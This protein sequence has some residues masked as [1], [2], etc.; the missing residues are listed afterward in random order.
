MFLH[1]CCVQP[2]D[3]EI[4]EEV[5][6]R[7]TANH[8]SLAYQIVIWSS[9]DLMHIVWHACIQM[10]ISN[11]KKKH[12]RTSCWIEIY[13]AK[14]KHFGSSISA[15]NS[16][17]FFFVKQ[18]VETSILYRIASSLLWKKKSKMIKKNLIYTNNTVCWI[19]KTTKISVRMLAIHNTQIH[20]MCVCMHY[21]V[22]GYVKVMS[23]KRPGK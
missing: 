16:F 21:Y 9:K 5:M 4:Q 11:T 22:I 7:D 6:K 19:A 12:C 15:A 8:S 13:I 10:Y 17:S 18:Q 20:G 23:M 3:K 1:C 14:K 2:G